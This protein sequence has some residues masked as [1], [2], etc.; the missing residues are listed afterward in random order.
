[1][2]R[3]LGVR[4]VLEGSVR[5]AGDRVRVTAQL[6][7][8]ATS[9]HI[10]AERYDR[11]VEDIFDVQDA[12]TRSIVAAVAPEVE[13]AELALARRTRP[14]DLK[15]YEIALQAWADCW[16]SYIRPDRAKRDRSIAR[17]EEALRIDP[18][19][20]R[21]L[22]TLSL[23]HWQHANF[24]TGPSLEASVKAG[25]DAAAQAV[26]L[27]RLNHQAFLFRGLSLW[28]AQ[29]FDEAM[30]DLRHGYDLNPNEA[31]SLIARG[32]GEVAMG[33]TEI[34][35]RLLTEA[36]RLSPRDPQQYNA[37]TCLCAAGFV[38]SNYSSGVEWGVIGKSRYPDYPP[39]HHYLALNYVGLGQLE[40]AAAE[41]ETLRRVA[42]EWLAERLAGFSALV[43]P[44]DRRR[45][46]DFLRQA[47]SV[48]V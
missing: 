29:R 16:E 27:D 5:R 11:I 42:P 6:I 13:G 2:G 3:E 18:R 46:I 7:E 43:R 24:R 14:A 8:A 33:N 39:L 10:W 25:I 35:E 41:V 17:A 34:G 45:S 40:R 9:A 4:Y 12:I 26:Q 30:M 20:V 47:A 31:G 1:V 32:W 44:A 37:Y 19:C 22:L 28:M 23:A 21:A 48:T 38:S 36:L 15:A